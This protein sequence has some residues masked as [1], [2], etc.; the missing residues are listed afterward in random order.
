MKDLNLDELYSKNVKLYR[1]KENIE[2]VNRYRNGDIKA[3]KS[4]VKGGLY[5]VRKIAKR[6]NK[7]FPEI[8]LNDLVEEGVVGLI[9][10][11]EKFDSNKNKLYST[12]VTYY[13]KKRIANYIKFHTNFY[14]VKHAIIKDQ[15]I[16]KFDG[17]YKVVDDEFFVFDSHANMLR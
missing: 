1:E 17:N 15:E 4:L 2:L 3:Y 7:L 8:D 16:K 10:S 5:R 11:I 9:E 12:F 14:D 13:I 6:Y